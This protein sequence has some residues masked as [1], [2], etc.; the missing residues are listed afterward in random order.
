MKE[1]AKS[2]K[3]LARSPLGIVALFLVLVYGVACLFFSFAVASLSVGQKW[4]II[5]FIILF[6]CIVLL[7]FYLLVTKHHSKLYTPADWKDESHFLEA[8]NIELPALKQADEGKEFD[9]EVIS[10]VKFGEEIVVIDGKQ[11]ER[12]EFQGTT[13]QFNAKKPVQLISSSFIEV[14]WIFG[15]S[16]SLT[17][18]FVST[19]YR[20]MGEEVGKPFIESVISLIKGTKEKSP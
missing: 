17:F 16:A 5:L 19:L 6:P 12:C 10:E 13:L 9:F 18:G 8:M 7:A 4:L 2:A 15:D 14:K 1:F 3:D 11:F 20:A